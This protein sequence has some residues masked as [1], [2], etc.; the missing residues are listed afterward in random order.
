MHRG[1]KRFEI[2]SGPDFFPHGYV[3]KEAKNDDEY[4]GALR[5]AAGLYC[6][7]SVR[8]IQTHKYIDLAVQGL[9]TA[10]RLLELLNMRQMGETDQAHEREIVKR[11][12][13]ERTLVTEEVPRVAGKR[14]TK[15]ARK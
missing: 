8:I 14:P 7:E 15:A 12:K 5:A 1:V 13:Y 4:S 10:V 2:P 3:S 6:H 9:R 11:E